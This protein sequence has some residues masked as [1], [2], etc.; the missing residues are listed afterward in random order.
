MVRACEFNEDTINKK[1]SQLE[2]SLSTLSHPRID[3]AEEILVSKKTRMSGKQINQFITQWF[4]KYADET[5]LN[6]GEDNFVST[7]EFNASN[8]KWIT[9][10]DD[11]YT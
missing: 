6:R 2:I 1:Y 5:H 11:I 3:N 9:R 4:R 10:L 7:K 8:L